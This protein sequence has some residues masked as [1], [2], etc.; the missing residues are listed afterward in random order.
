LLHLHPLTLEDI[1]Q[2]ET[3]EKLEL[4]PRLGYYFVV[5]HALESDHTRAK[6]TQI[7]LALDGDNT[8]IFDGKVEA[9]NLYII[10]FRDGICTVSPIASGIYFNLM[11]FQFHFED[12]SDHIHRVQNRIKQLEGTFHMSSGKLQSL[13]IYYR[14]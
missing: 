8:P 13:V 1:L 7:S 6:T 11:S 12:I 3:R 14:R 10:V 2:Q 5:F 4:F 9:T